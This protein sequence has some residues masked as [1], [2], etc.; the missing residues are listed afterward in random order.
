MIQTYS[1]STSAIDLAEEALADIRRQMEGVVLR[2]HSIG[3]VVCHYDFLFSG[4]YDAICGHLP[5]EVVGFT[6]FNQATPTISGLFEMTITLLTSDDVRFYTA[7]NVSESVEADIP[8]VVHAATGRARDD[9]EAPALMISFLGQNTAFTGDAYLRATDALLPD[10]PHFGA[11]SAGEDEE[12]SETYVLHNGHKIQQGYVLLLMTGSIQAKFFF[13]AHPENSML[14]QTATVTKADGLWVQTVNNQPTLAFLKRNGF[15]D[16]EDARTGLVTLPVLHT[17]KG[18]TVSI[19]RTLVDYND[20]GHMLFFGEIPEGSV[21]RMGTS[22]V[23]DILGVTR[24]V[25]QSAVSAAG[26]N[27]LLLLFSCVGRYIALGLDTNAELSC[28]TA[29]IPARLPYL[30]AYAGGEICPVSIGGTLSNRFHNSSVIACV[31]E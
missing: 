3:I 25:V 22:T 23:E 5:F 11:I 30:I 24:G 31:L 14:E 7:S 27:A 9:G 10:I 18:E 20:E 29:E 19:A 28:A 13:G 6:T 15:D 8:A 4:V 26:E 17:R 12:G 21:L 16:S 1:L 2:R